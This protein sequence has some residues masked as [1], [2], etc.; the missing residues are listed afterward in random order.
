MDR[1]Q[2]SERQKSQK[3][4]L[5]ESSQLLAMWL[6]T[7]TQ[8]FHQE[9]EELAAAAYKEILKGFT[10]AQIDRGCRECLRRCTFFPKPAEIIEAIHDTMPV[11]PIVPLLPSPRMTQ[12]DFKNALAEARERLAPI[13]EKVEEP[14]LPQEGVVIIT[15]EM[16]ATAKRKAKEATERFGK[17]A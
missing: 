15:D 3:P 14:P 5:V 8:V 2:G 7:F 11:A 9:I 1:Q 17:S 10:A 4:Q 16:R 12:E 6:L 13:L